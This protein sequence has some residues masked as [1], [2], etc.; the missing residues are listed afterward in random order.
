VV[1]T[2]TEYDAYVIACLE[3]EFRDD[4]SDSERYDDALAAIKSS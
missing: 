1:L 2:A 4:Y 3:T